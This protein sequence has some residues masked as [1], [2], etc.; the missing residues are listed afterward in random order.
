MIKMG[1][2]EVKNGIYSVGILNPAMRIF[3]VI[4]RTEYGTTY[5]SYVVKGSEKTALI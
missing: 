1:A 5:N 3:D 2:V 4:M